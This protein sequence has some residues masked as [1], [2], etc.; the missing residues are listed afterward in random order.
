MRCVECQKVGDI[1]IYASLFPGTRGK[2]EMI[3]SEVTTTR[4]AHVTG[5][6]RA[7][8][9]QEMMPE[10]PHKEQTTSAFSGFHRKQYF[11]LS[12]TGSAGFVL[13]GME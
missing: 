5:A 4:I 6:A 2:E 1:K 3:R 7:S 11:V 13:S 9:L 10:I 12:Q 8:C